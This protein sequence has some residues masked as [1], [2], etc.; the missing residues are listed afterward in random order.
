MYKE[1]YDGNPLLILPIVAMLSFFVGFLVILARF[2]LS[3]RNRK[4]QEQNDQ[5]AQLPLA[6]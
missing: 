1:F 4:L 2:V 6:D 3:G 5:L